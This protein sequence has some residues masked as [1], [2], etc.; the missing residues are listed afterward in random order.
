M[1]DIDI[2]NGERELSE[3]ND[4]WAHDRIICLRNFHVKLT[5]RKNPRIFVGNSKK[6]IFEKKISRNMRM[7]S[8]ENK[9]NKKVKDI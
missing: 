6:L 4:F 9:F 1:S 5:S 2:L 3:I 8:G 7:K